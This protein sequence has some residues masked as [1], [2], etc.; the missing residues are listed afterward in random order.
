MPKRFGDL[1]EKTFTLERMYEAYF[2]ARKAKRK[3]LSVARFERDLGANLVKLQTEILDGTY[4]PAPYRHFVIYSPKAR[5]ISAPSFRDVVAQH[6]IHLTILPIFEATFLKDS[7]GCRIGGGAHRASDSLQ[8]AL[9]KAS[10]EAYILQMDIRKFY[11]RVHHE[12]LRRLFERKIKD[13]RLVELMM[14]F[15]KDG[16]STVGLP[17]G[18]LLSQLYALIYLNALDHYVK[19]E[20]KLSNFARYVDDF[21]MVLPDKLTAQVAKGQIESWLYRSLKLELSRATTT[22]IKKGANFVGF[23]TWRS[24]RFVR[25]RSLHRFSKSLKA[26]KTESLVSIVGNAYN[27]STLSYFVKRLSAERPDIVLPKRMRSRLCS[28]HTQNTEP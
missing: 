13:T 14:V 22:P 4:Q 18:N 3:T 11:Y 21:I 23:R 20:L 26:G 2:N 9:R 10:P 19:R 16:D 24:R 5:N 17:I 12:I 1:F 6:A 28:M 25:K 15:V 8:N 27:T 7:Y